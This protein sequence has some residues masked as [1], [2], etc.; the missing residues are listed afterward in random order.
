MF[1]T[2]NYNITTFI[3]YT[4]LRVK[5]KKE[6][7]QSSKYR[8]SSSGPCI[9]IH[10]YIN[11]YIHIYIYYVIFHY[12]YH[13]LYPYHIV[14]NIHVLW[15]IHIH[16]IYTYICFIYI[17]M[18]ILHIQTCGWRRR[19]SGSSH[20]SRGPRWAARTCVCIISY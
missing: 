8:S 14:H 11:I 10:T 12:I 15:M 17:Y 5:E 18:H 7:E 4:D 9:Y 2:Y 3:I 6:R 16:C 1:C 13:I 20:R 19:R